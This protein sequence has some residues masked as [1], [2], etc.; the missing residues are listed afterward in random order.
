MFKMKRARLW[1]RIF[2]RINTAACVI[3]KNEQNDISEWIA[4]HL[5]IGFDTILLF[6]NMS[7][8]GTSRIVDK[9]AGMYDVRRIAWNDTSTRYQ[10][11]AYNSA[12]RMLRQDYDWLCFIDADEFLL[13]KHH[14]SIREF[15]ADH[16]NCPAVAV[17]WAIFGSSGLQQRP[18]GLV[19]ENF[20]QRSDV[21]FAP[22]RHVKCLVQPRQTKYCVNAHY[23]EVK[24]GFVSPLGKPLHWELPGLSSD[25]PEYDSARINHYFVKSSQQWSG[26]MKR[27]Y[28]D[29]QRSIEIFSIYDRNEVFDRDILGLSPAAHKIMSKLQVM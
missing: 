22:N 8:D 26:K 19:I 6:D 27:G 2:R 24:G 28:H 18:S 4:Y 7:N 12:L 14:A 1:P 10:V 21:S 16:A 15:V 11:K 17:N 23:F 5:A 9:Y 3:V 20:L 25:M 13:L 29:T